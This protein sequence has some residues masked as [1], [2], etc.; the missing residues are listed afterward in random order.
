[1]TPLHVLSPSHKFQSQ[2]RPL[3]PALISSTT[4]DFLT[5][6]PHFGIG[7]SSPDSQLWPNVMM[8]VSQENI[9]AILLHV[10]SHETFDYVLQKIDKHKLQDE[11]IPYIF[12]WFLKVYFI[13]TLKK[14]KKSIVE[15]I[16]I[17]IAKI[18]CLKQHIFSFTLRSYNKR[19]I[20][21]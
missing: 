18:A 19:V 11:K 3:S 21:Y 13:A 17:I 9:R 4:Q 16:I 6:I 15:K 1:M 14:K 5:E 2:M 12:S 10:V 7:N 8:A 20:I